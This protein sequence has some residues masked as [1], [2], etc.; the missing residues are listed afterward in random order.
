MTRKLAWL[1]PSK[2]INRRLPDVLDLLPWAVVGVACTR[3]TL[4]RSL[5]NF[6]RSRPRTCELHLRSGT[7]SLSSDPTCKLSP[8]CFAVPVT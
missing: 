7:A 5:V 1:V 6:D 3:Q 2:N 4:R 8:V